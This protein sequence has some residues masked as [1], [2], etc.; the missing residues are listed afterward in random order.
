MSKA[1]DTM[2]WLINRELELE[3]DYQYNNKCMG[4][5]FDTSLIKDLINCEKELMYNRAKGIDKLVWGQ[6]IKE[7]IEKY[8]N[9]L[10]G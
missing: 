6:I 10:E 8:L 7:D 9:R 3:F 4:Y 2:I 1:K 5:E